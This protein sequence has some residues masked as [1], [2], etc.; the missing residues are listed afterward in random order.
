MRGNSKQ[1]SDSLNSTIERRALTPVEV[2]QILNLGMT[3][4]YGRLQRGETPF[5]VRRVGRRWLIPKKPFF[6]W[7]DGEST[8]ASK[9]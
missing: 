9:G 2:A 1:S 6:E 8:D 7:L 3:E 4:L 5:P